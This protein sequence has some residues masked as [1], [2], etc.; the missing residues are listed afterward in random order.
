MTIKNSGK[1][2]IQK[3]KLIIYLFVLAVVFA[4]I[5]GNGNLNLL[6]FFGLFLIF[7]NLKIQVSFLKD[8]VIFF[9]PFCL[10]ILGE[11]FLSGNTFSPVKVLV[12]SLK[13]LVCISLLSY[14]KKRFW[15]VDHLAIIKNI[16]G[17]FEIMLIISL[18][19][20]N[21]PIFWRLNDAINRFS[22]TRL[23]FL[24]SEPSVLGILCGLLVIILLY[25][26]FDNKKNYMLLKEIV[27]LAVI[28]LL[29]FSMS[30]IVYTA[31]GII[32]LFLFQVFKNKEGI[33]R[34]MLTYF[35]LGI[36]LLIIILSTNNPISNRFFS[37]FL[38]TDGSYNFRWSAAVNVFRKT[39]EI[40]KYWGMGLGN[41]N[42][43]S[44]LSFLLNIGIDYKF[45]NSF[46]YFFTENGILGIIYTIY[47]FLICTYNCI[48]SSKNIRP[49]KVGVLAFVFVGQIAGGYYTDP[50]LWIMYGIVCS[51]EKTVI[52]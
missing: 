47:L 14:T 23:K 10:M 20:I 11:I 31:V 21:K 5:L 48:K 26:I 38:G 2:I 12:Y 49:L 15:V 50:I 51:N 27:L 45:A 37:M 8:M 43:P 42:T 52:N 4:D 13:I 29:T 18:L 17:L 36:C 3:E 35:L 34:R 33:P 40:T 46:L 25:Y 24:Y 44:G 1:F 7:K 32:V 41:M 28:I 39:M 30:G 22:E 19:T 9:V 16:C 6:Y